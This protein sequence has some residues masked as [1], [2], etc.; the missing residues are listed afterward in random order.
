MQPPCRRTGQGGMWVTER[1]RNGKIVCAPPRRCHEQR[2]KTF[3]FL[4]Y[5]IGRR[6]SLGTSAREG[7]VGLGRLCVCVWILMQRDR[8]LISLSRAMEFYRIHH[9]RCQVR[10]GK[11]YAKSHVMIMSTTYLTQYSTVVTADFIPE[12]FFI[13]NNSEPIMINTLIRS[14]PF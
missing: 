14:R 4:F 6:F 9:W 5:K 8:D 2:N 11:L 1:E 12:S 13:A 7:S 10:R 3:L